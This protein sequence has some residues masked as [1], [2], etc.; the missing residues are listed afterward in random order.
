MIRSDRA[1]T[2]ATLHDAA[3]SLSSH[4]AVTEVRA[5]S[6]LMSDTMRQ[7]SLRVTLLSW[8]SV[9]T[10]LLAAIGTFGLVSQSVRQRQRELAIGSALGANRKRL[11]GSI[12]SYALAAAAAGVVVGGLGALALVCTM[13]VSCTASPRTTRVLCRSGARP[14]RCHHRCRGDSSVP[15][16]A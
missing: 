2:A 12:V 3:T 1:L 11:V 5:V 15:C 14:P 6:T 4:A 10:V 16:D 7:P 8:L 9:A 13:Q